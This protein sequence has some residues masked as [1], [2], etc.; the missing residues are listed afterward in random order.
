M[1]SNSFGPDG[2]GIGDVRASASNSS[3]SGTYRLMR[4]KTLSHGGSTFTRSV[5]VENDFGLSKTGGYL[6]FMLSGWVNEYYMGIMR[7]HNA[8]GGDGIISA[9]I[10]DISSRGFTV[11]ATHDSD[12]TVTFNVSGAHTNGHGFQFFVWCGT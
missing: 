8:G 5:H 10:I 7:W 2:F 6:R 9:E 3:G 4:S 11:T 1:P 12:K